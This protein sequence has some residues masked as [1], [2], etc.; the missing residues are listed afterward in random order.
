MSLPG[1]CKE[2]TGC[3]QEPIIKQELCTM[4]SPSPTHMYI[5]TREYRVIPPVS[6]GCHHSSSTDNEHKLKPVLESA[7]HTR[8]AADDAL[9]ESRRRLVAESD[10]WTTSSFQR[11]VFGEELDGWTFKHGLSNEAELTLFIDKVQL[12]DLCFDV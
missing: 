9:A 3:K 12:G 11:P 5:V 6:E 2:E 4:S 10:G 8:A 7:W 1:D